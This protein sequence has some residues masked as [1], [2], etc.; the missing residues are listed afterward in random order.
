MATEF[1]YFSFLPY[2]N[3]AKYSSFPE[4]VYNLY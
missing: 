2:V 4:A 3:D 1:N